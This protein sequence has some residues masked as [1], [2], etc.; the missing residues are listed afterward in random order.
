M[1]IPNANLELQATHL[2]EDGRGVGQDGETKIYV[3]D[4]LPG[5]RAEIEIEHRSRHHPK[6]WGRIVKREGELSAD[7]A[8]PDCPAFRKCG[9]CTWQHLAYP[10]QLKQKRQR[11]QRAFE[12]VLENPPAIPGVAAAPNPLHYRNKGK[13]VFGLQEGA[14]VLGAYKPRSHEVVSTLG[15]KVVEAGIDEVAA[16][17]LRAAKKAQMPVYQEGVASDEAEISPGLRYAILRSN[18][19]AG[20]LVTLVCTSSTPG[21]TLRGLAQTL[22]KHPHVVGVLR[23]DNDLQSVALLTD[24]V[25]LLSGQPSLEEQLFGNPIALGPLSFWQVHRKQAELA[26]RAIAEAL[27]VKPDSHVL[28]LYAGI[29][30]IAVALASAGHKV[31]GVDINEEAVRTANALAQDWGLSD[32]LGFVCADAT[33]LDESFFENVSA[34][35]VDPPR[36]GLGKRGIA[37][38]CRA[39]PAHIAYLS[40]GPESLAADLQKLVSAGYEIESIQPFDFMP[41]TAQVECLAVLSR[42]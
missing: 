15:C 36:K 42:V 40:C 2:A 17:I 41:G 37:Q 33:N 28:E 22:Q 6:A 34:V 4:L 29:G 25:T 18:D 24:E 30:G 38:L 1:S 35:V 12:A 7:R 31:V 13:Y 16:R 9:G 19:A 39:M 27:P 21:E 10:A 32:S 11:L 20:V 3:A 5:E 14:I 8:T 26:Y 23:C